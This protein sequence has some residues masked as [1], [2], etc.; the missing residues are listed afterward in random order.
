MA[1]FDGQ[2]DVVDFLA[3]EYHE[4]KEREKKIQKVIEYVKQ[5]GNSVVDLNPICYQLKI[6]LT[7]EEV[8]YICE[9]CEED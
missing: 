6:R 3:I 5:N 9:Q 1:L 4:K 8:Q 7:A 2:L